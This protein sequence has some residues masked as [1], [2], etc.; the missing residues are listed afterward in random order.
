MNVRLSVVC[1]THRRVWAQP[2]DQVAIRHVPLEFVCHQHSSR[3][4]CLLD[5][6]TVSRRKGD[7]VLYDEQRDYCP[8]PR[9]ED[10]PD[11]DNSTGSAFGS[12]HPI[13]R[14][15]RGD[16]YARYTAFDLA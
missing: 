3:P 5:A 14:G 15:L 12:A 2:K 8:L 7:I 1:R 9:S 11:Y 4:K 13:H 16:F 6:V 10:R